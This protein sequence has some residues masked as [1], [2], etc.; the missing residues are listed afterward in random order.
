ML[1]STFIVGR[2]RARNLTAL[3]ACTV[4][5]PV[6]VGAK[7]LSGFGPRQYCGTR[8]PAGSLP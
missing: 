5:D 1:F 8:N 3:K 4:Q 6:G 7:V 2:D